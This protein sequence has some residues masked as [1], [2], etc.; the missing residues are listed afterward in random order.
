[1][2][3]SCGYL[4]QILP[5]SAPLPTLPLGAA[6]P[7]AAPP[8]PAA[9]AAAA[10][11]PATTPFVALGSRYFSITSGGWIISNSAVASLP[12]KVMIAS[13]PP[14]W[15]LRKLVTSKTRSWR[16]TQQSALLLWVATSDRSKVAA[17][18]AGAAPPAASPPAAAAPPAPVL[19][20]PESSC[21][22]VGT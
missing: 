12:A 22:D 21:N 10:A 2:C 8:P 18:A 20:A 4:P 3:V 17:A 19:Y 11:E 9:A 1:M 15:S 14:G 13:S 7:P 5:S 16:T 6:D